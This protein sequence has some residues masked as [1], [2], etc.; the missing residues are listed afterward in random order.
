MIEKK[1]RRVKA[2]TRVDIMVILGIAILIWITRFLNSSQFGF[3]ADDISRIPQ[4]IDMSW[5]GLWNVIASLW[6]EFGRARPLHSILIYL[7]SFIGWKINGLQGVYFLAYIILVTN[8]AL[9]YTLMRRITNLRMAVFG[10]LAYCLFAADTTQTLLTHTFGLQTALTFILLAGHF[11]L[12]RRV[13]FAYLTSGLALI[14]YETAFP[15]F[16]AMPLLFWK[17]D[18]KNLRFEGIHIAVTTMMLVVSVFAKSLT[19]D[20]RMI[21]S[22][23]GDILAESITHMLQGPAVSL[24]TY[25]YR[26]VQVILTKELAIY[27]VVF[28]A[29]LM[30]G[31]V[32]FLFFKTSDQV[33]SPLQELIAFLQKREMLSKSTKQILRQL[34]AGIFCLLLAYPLTLTIRA[35]AISGRDTRVHLA[36]VIGAAIIVA[37]IL[38]FLLRSI[39]NRRILIA[40]YTLITLEFAFLAGYGFMLQRD[41]ELAWTY[42]KQFLQ[43]VLEVCPD[44]EEGT[45]ILVEPDGLLDVRQVDAN[46]WNLA[47]LL[48]QV[49]DFPDEWQ[50]PARIVRLL[51]DWEDNILS[52][53]GKIVLNGT[54]VTSPSHVYEEYA[55]E[56]V[57]LLLT[58]ANQVRRATSLVE[59]GDHSIQLKEPAE[60]TLAD[61]PH[62]NLY[63]LM[64]VNRNQ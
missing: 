15:V 28:I 38:E 41:Y 9:F 14:C 23:F 33:S 30:I 48:E 32:S 13:L 22:S 16:I 26:V 45:L 11:L 24:G 50:T 3:Y 54:T 55:S 53:E 61:Y 62:G 29:T 40:L 42:Q 31:V 36:A 21:G 4:V 17:W 52:S 63:D 46:T 57:I 37:C 5:A 7:L 47:R 12:S 56:N 35:Y 64:L 1:Q 25:G 44:I 51:P 20:V 6:R 18:K 39:R 34:L 19:G 27:G 2:F 59:I 8:A 58:E 10:A 43:Q 60:S 49:Y